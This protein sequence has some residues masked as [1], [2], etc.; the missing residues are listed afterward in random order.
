MG[1]RKI[2]KGR[3]KAKTSQY[4]KDNIYLCNISFSQTFQLANKCNFEQAKK[5][6]TSLVMS[7]VSLVIMAQL[8]ISSR[9]QKSEW[10]DQLDSMKDIKRKIINSEYGLFASACFAVT[11]AFGYVMEEIRA[12]EDPYGALASVVIHLVESYDS[13][14]RRI[15][16]SKEN[17]LLHA[18]GEMGAVKGQM[19][20]CPSTNITKLNID[21]AEAISYGFEDAIR[22][23]GLSKELL[24]KYELS[25]EG[26]KL[27]YRNIMLTDNG[28]L[29]IDKLVYNEPKFVSSKIHNEILGDALIRVE[30]VK[31][32][33]EKGVEPFS[34]INTTIISKYLDEMEYFAYNAAI[35]TGD[36]KM[37]RHLT[38]IV[39]ERSKG[40]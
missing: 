7:G 22:V 2:K 1:L 27:K 26:L 17:W 29:P 23:M 30:T 25:I 33:L 4:N 13:N 35:R 11:M 32:S 16:P 8:S 14:V 28:G 39:L 5:F 12:R 6:I 19:L 34:A 31:A 18:R 15:K 20:S 40:H 21:G 24:D 38:N 37:A 10:V 3:N 9:P 36:V